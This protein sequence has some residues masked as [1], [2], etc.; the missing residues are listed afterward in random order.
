ML[1]RRFA[2]FSLLDMFPT[3]DAR[4]AAALPDY[5][6]FKQDLIIRENNS[7]S[8]FGKKKSYK[9]RPSLDDISSA[10]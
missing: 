7:I 1:S 2:D 3:F 5:R 9:F 4:L 8:G 6:E 10:N